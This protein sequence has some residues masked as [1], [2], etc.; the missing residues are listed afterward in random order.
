M[1]SVCPVDGSIAVTVTDTNT[2]LPGAS[3]S[4]MC[5]GGLTV[6][7]AHV[8]VVVHEM[9]FA[10]ATI[11][12][13][14]GALPVANPDELIPAIDGFVL[15][16]WTVGNE[17]EPPPPEPPPL[18]PPLPEVTE[19]SPGGGVWN[20]STVARARLFTCPPMM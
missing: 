4:V 18:E 7:L 20:A 3:V 13:W 1:P 11:V 15:C 14:P 9:P 8:F 6:R 2:A 17:L 5:D 16:H 19:R 10:V 12:V